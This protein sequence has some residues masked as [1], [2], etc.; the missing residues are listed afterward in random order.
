M[1]NGVGRKGGD[2]L[3]SI[4]L[5]DRKVEV[6]GG[7]RVTLYLGRALNLHGLHDTEIKHRMSKAWA[8]FAIYRK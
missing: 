2:I 1:Y 8:K 7:D 3:G 5:A 4:A 6:L